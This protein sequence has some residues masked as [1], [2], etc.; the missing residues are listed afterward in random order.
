MVRWL[1][2]EEQ[3]CSGGLVISLNVGLAENC[4]W[5]IGIR[6]TYLF[7]CSLDVLQFECGLNVGFNVVLSENCWL[8]GWYQRHRLVVGR[9]A[10]YRV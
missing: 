10:D 5:A 1:V 3:T 4:W 9:A 6:G 7:E 8:V 2:S